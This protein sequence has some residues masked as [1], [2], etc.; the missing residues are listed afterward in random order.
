MYPY[1][2]VKTGIM[3]ECERFTFYALTMTSDNGVLTGKPNA[4]TYD[5]NL[6]HDEY[7]IVG[8]LNI[9]LQRLA[10]WERDG[11]VREG[12]VIQHI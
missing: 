4:E 12:H 9:M 8:L 2:A 11:L 5:C 10:D 6:A 7:I 3:T 1:I